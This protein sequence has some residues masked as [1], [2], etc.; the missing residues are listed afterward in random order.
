MSSFEVQVTYTLLH[1]LLVKLSPPAK[2]FTILHSE[3]YLSDIHLHPS[4]VYL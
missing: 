1:P 4:N 2:F 3:G